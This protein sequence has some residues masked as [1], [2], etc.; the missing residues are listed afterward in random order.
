VA[1]V[2]SGSG[3]DER[4]GWIATFGLGGRSDTTMR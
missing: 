1:H 4:S 2:T 3:D